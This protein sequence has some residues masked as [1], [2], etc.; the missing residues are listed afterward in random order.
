MQ[1]FLQYSRDQQIER[2]NNPT[3]YKGMK[4]LCDIDR[5]CEVEDSVFDWQQ[6]DL[7]RHT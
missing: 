5:I 6:Y 2:Y 4:I 7:N 3:D 1:D